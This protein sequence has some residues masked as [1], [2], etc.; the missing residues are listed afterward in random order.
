MAFPLGEETHTDTNRLQQKRLMSMCFLS[1]VS[2]KVG[3]LIVPCSM[4]HVEYKLTR[5]LLK[6]L[7]PMA[8]SNLSVIW[9]STRLEE[10]K[11]W[12][13][14]QNHLLPSPKEKDLGIKQK[15]TP[16]KKLEVYI[17]YIYIFLWKSIAVKT[18]TGKYYFKTYGV[19]SE[20]MKPH[21]QEL[22]QRLADECEERICGQ[23]RPPFNVST[24]WCG[25]IFF[26]FSPL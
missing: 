3:V 19:S 9:H 2:S 22:R 11:M 17:L 14:N 15:I 6:A 1:F 21:H 16:P 8:A 7:G 12:R 23:R 13:F 5:Y 18:C 10:L 26:W 4:F 24:W 20:N 25:F